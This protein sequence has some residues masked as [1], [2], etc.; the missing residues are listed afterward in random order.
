MHAY[1]NKE[2]FNLDFLV[3]CNP[4]REECLG[5]EALKLVKQPAALCDVWGLGA[6]PPPWLSHSS[7]H[8]VSIPLRM[9]DVG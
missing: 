1:G 7:L 3:S 2:K 6:G 8:S 4:A 9:P 5:S